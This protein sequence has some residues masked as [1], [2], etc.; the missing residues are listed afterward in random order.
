M[1][2]GPKK[3][4]KQTFQTEHNIVK[5]PNWSEANQLAIYKRG[6]GFD[7]G[8]TEK[9]IQVVVRA[10]LE[11]KTA[12]LRVQHVNHLA[13]QPPVYNLYSFCFRKQANSKQA[14]PVPY[15]IINYLLT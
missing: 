14:W 6:R 2:V 13:T 1:L 4:L 5:N 12:G 8:A 11:P 3:Q 7:F 9:Q 15:N 10:G